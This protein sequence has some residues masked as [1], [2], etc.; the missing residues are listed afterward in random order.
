MCGNC[1]RLI[2]QLQ[3]E[4]D[5]PSFLKVTLNVLL[6]FHKW[7]VS[8]NDFISF[9]GFLGL[10]LRFSFLKFIG[11]GLGL[12]LNKMDLAYVCVS[13]VLYEILYYTQSSTYMYIFRIIFCM[14]LNIWLHTKLLYEGLDNAFVLH[15]LQTPSFKFSQIIFASL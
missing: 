3:F 4:N 14:V 13:W 15:N 1:F 11:L 7:F 12:R 8:K 9:L 10:G 6:G 5:H 2:F